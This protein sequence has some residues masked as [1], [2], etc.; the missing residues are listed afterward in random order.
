MR[1]VKCQGRYP[2]QPVIGRSISTG[3]EFHFSSI[4]EAVEQ[5]F[6]AASIRKCLAGQMRQTAGFE[7]AMWE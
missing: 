4:A 1:K 5:G 2:A 7:W 6:H 3:E